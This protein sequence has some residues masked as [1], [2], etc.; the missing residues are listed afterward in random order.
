MVA[1][2]NP[3]DPTGEHLSAGTLS[4]LIERLPDDVWVLLDEA[5][6]DFVEAQ[7]ADTMAL[8]DDHPRLLVFRTFSKIY[9]LAGMHCGYV[10]GGPGTEDLL[11]RVG[12]LLAVSDIVQAGAI[13]ALRKCG[14]QIERRRAAVVAERHRLA[15]AL[16][17][18][19]IEASPS[20]ANFVW[21]RPRGL[22]GGELAARLRRAA[23]IVRPGTEWGDDEHARAALQSP[24]AT[25]RLVEGLR[26]ALGA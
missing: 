3:N 25:D 14:A 11:Q 22:T 17:G 26:G 1:I 5:L 13:E 4:A 10:L 23:V 12:P 6:A 9:G 8:L 18:L 24:P 20:Q 2:A 15:E 7:D 19:P 21:L 16:A